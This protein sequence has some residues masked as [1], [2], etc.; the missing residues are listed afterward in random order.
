MA[1]WGEWIACWKESQFHNS[2]SCDP[3]RQAINSNP[4]CES[5]RL[6]REQNSMIPNLWNDF[7]KEERS[8]VVFLKIFCHTFFCHYCFLKIALSSLGP[9]FECRFTHFTLVQVQ[10]NFW[11]PTKNSL[12]QV[13]F[14]YTLQGRWMSHHS[15][16]SGWLWLPRDHLGTIFG[17]R[18]LESDGIRSLN[19]TRSFTRS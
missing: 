7:K 4:P 3:L 17:K 10:R 14:K 12:G 6:G 8:R 5:V 15:P 1:V 18:F 9:R 19:F 13:G 2:E 16:I 11:T